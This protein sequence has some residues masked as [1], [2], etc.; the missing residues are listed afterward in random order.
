MVDTI[1]NK[2]GMT[3]E[4]EYY[5]DE[6]HV[7]EI[8][9]MPFKDNI[10]A[11]AIVGETGLIPYPT[12]YDDEGNPLPTRYREGF[13]VDIMTTEVIQEWKPYTVTGGN[14]WAHSFGYGEVVTAEDF[15][16]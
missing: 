7:L 5:I 3:T 2:D 15:E 14:E 10:M 6:K 1:I 8:L 9:T 16:I 12:E 13:H 11:I 4:N